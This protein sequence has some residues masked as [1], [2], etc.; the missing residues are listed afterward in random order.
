MKRILC[1]IITIASL[2]LVSCGQTA[3]PI[4][5][6]MPTTATSSRGTSTAAISAATTATET[7]GMTTAT[8]ATSSKIS[9]A[10]PEPTTASPIVITTAETTATT[11]TTSPTTATET[12]AT[13]SPTNIGTPKVY[14][15]NL[16]NGKYSLF[17]AKSIETKS[18]VMILEK[19]LYIEALYYYSKADGEFYPFCF[20]PFCDH[21]DKTK[22]IGAML[23]DPLRAPDA[24]RIYNING[25]FYFAA[26][27]KIYS[28]SEFATDLRVELSVDTKI[29]SFVNDEN[30]LLFLCVDSDGNIVQYVYDTVSKK[31]MDLRKKMTEKEKEI[32]ASLYTYSFANGKVYM[33]AYSN[34]KK[35]T[36]GGQFYVNVEGD[37][38]GWYFA[39]YDFKSFSE[40]DNVPSLS[41]AFSTN[42]GNVDI[43]HKNEE[44]NVVDIVHLRFD[45][46]VEMI[47]E[48]IVFE[49][50]PFPIYMTDDSFYFRFTYLIELGI[51]AS[52]GMKRKSQC[53]G[54]IYRL[55]LKTGE[56]QTVFD[57]LSYD[58]FKVIYIDESSQYGFMTLQK[59]TVEDGLVYS[60][61]GLLYQ[62]KLDENGNIVDLERV[63]F[64]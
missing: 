58:Y 21:R 19:I 14:G 60:Q 22:C 4:D 16:S 24:D 63:E 2:L 8:A 47:A 53:G 61:A 55:D 37:F 6:T 40:T 44:G 15:E 28:C 52:T 64:E 34:V 32:G 36:E 43:R 30:Y 50:K 54:K 1:L 49:K 25:R 26:Y 62:F 29:S 5:Y 35:A 23:L 10:A 48:N 18:K 11:A 39:D 17:G 33:A 42:Y 45:G 59:Y 9:T 27:G 46:T 38:E 56:I 51:N 7:A 57:N 41:Y 20:D 31:L 12:T 13:T 3:V